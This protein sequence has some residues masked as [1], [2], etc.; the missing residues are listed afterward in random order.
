MFEAKR[1][2]D[3]EVEPEKQQTPDHQCC[4]KFAELMKHELDENA[5]LK[6]GRASWLKNSAMDHVLQTYYHTG[7]LQVALK[8]LMMVETSPGT[9]RS[10]IEFLKAQ[11]REY[12]ADV[13]NHAMMVLDTLEILGIPHPPKKEKEKVEK[14]DTFS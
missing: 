4:T 8:E 7:K 9:S 2:V 14:Y 5:A 1:K 11:V 13:G 3:V 12:A 10:K 6:K